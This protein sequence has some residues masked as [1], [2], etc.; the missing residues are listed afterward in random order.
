MEGGSRLGEAIS[1]AYVAVAL[2]PATE[3]AARQMVEAVKA[4][5]DAD[6][7][8]LAWMSAATKAR[9]KQK[10]RA[11]VNHVGYPERW[12]DDTA[13]KIVRG[14]AYGNAVRAS[15][16]KGR[17][18]IAM[19]GQPVERGE[20][21][22][23]ATAADASYDVRTNA[24]TIPAALLQPPI[25]DRR[26]TDAEN[27]GHLGSIIGHV[28]LYAF[29]RD[30]RRLNERGELEDWWPPEDIRRFD[31][32]TAC[33]VAEYNRFAASN[34]V[35][36]DGARTLDENIADCGAMQLAY[37]AFL[38]DAEHKGTDLTRAQDGHTPIQQFFLG[39]GQRR[40]V[41]GSLERNSMGGRRAPD[42]VRVN[43]VVQNMPE[44]GRAFGCKVGQP[45][46]PA[47]TCRVW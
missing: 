3:R 28:L 13:L 44:F 5:L 34:D 30:D 7:D 35:R 15:E 43:G 46:M 11:I 41:T 8:T 17:R 9:A 14:D 39:Y 1:Q 29:D 42:R 21:L 22:R 33:M 12:R 25:Y 36:V 45:M 20:W 16:L 31:D 6:I 47:A 10:V 37:A 23:G 38:A 26:S 27:Y 19:I 24:I 18:D 32:Q 40:C 4:A 2:A